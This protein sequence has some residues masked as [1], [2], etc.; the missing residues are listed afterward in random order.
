[1][2]LEVVMSVVVS[3]MSL[4]NIYVYFRYIGFMFSG[5]GFQWLDST[6]FK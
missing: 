4:S 3:S 2:K 5:S 6:F 1:M